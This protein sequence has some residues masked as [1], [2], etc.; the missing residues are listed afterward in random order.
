MQDQRNWLEKL[1]E[2][3]PGYGGYQ[4]KERRRDIDKL[5]REHL[6]NQLR[7]TKTPLMDLMRDMT[8]SG[9]L[10]ETTPVDRLIKKIDKL[11]NRIRFASYGYSGF[12]DQVKI[13]EAELN[14]IYQFDLSLVTRVEQL[15]EKARALK[16]QSSDGFKSAVA[17]AEQMADELDRTFDQR[18]NAING[19]GGGANQPPGQPMFGAS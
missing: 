3:I 7:A 8:S 9:R 6:A 12:F 14:A 4:D 5:Q 11:E 18:Y 13:Q 1:T 2:K 10:F 19:G 17:E 16:S 15:E